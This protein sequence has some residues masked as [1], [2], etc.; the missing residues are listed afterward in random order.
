M[1]DDIAFESKNLYNLANYHIRQ[2]FIITSKLSKGDLIIAEQQDYLSWIN[3][4]VDDYNNKKQVN[5]DKKKLKNPDKYT[6][7]Y[8]LPLPYF[9]AEHKYL[10][11]NFLEYLLSKTD[12]YRAL[13]AQTAQQ[14]LK[15]LD[16]N[17]QS[18]FV[19]IKDYSTN[20][21][22]YLGRPKLPKYKKKN[23]RNVAIFTNQQSKIKNNCVTFP[24][25][26]T[27]L[28]TTIGEGLQQVRI[29]PRGNIYVMEVVYDKPLYNNKVL[30]NDNIAGIDLGLN[31]FATITNNIGLKPI[32]INGKIIKSFN[33]Y[34]NKM[35][36]YN[37][38]ILKKQY[39]RDWS[40]RLERLN[41]KRNN[42]IDDF[43]HKTSKFVIDYCL[44]NNFS[45]VVIGHND[46]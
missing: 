34:Y 31:N 22:K 26:D 4:N 19:S 37:K 21:G 42:K 46:G 11:Y 36:A 3:S 43:M 12:A 44:T 41:R 45:T 40:N 8:Y 13:P 9:D 29:I 16:K 25:T 23:G 35:L 32:V 24:K 15:L 1:C 10:G 27:K 33:Q 17:W 20:K 6:D 39:D 30:A 5:L 28:K 18:F 2:V 14:V 38:S 7:K